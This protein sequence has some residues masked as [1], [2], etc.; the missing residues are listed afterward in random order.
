M[1]PGG[2]Y[3]D[4]LG[5][6]S[7]CLHFCWLSI[8][9]SVSLLFIASYFDCFVCTMRD[10]R[11]PVQIKKCLHPYRSGVIQLNVERSSDLWRK[12]GSAPWSP[13]I[14]IPTG[15]S[16]LTHDPT[17]TLFDG[18]ITCALHPTLSPNDG[19]SWAANRLMLK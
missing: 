3:E 11:D 12:S 14:E 17:R 13:V 9:S 5:H 10:F 8:S 18:T 1:R 7:K 19:L 16:E 4:L 15:E 6:G 2:N